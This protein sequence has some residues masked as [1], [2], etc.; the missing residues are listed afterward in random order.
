[1]TSVELFHLTE[2]EAGSV[3]RVELAG[4]EVAIARVGDDIY[5]IGDKCSHADVPLSEG[6]VDV[7]E[8]TIECSAHGALFDLAT[9]EPL[10]L[11]AV[12]PVPVYDVAVVD[13]MVVL[14]MDDD[15]DG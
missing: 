1:M 10:T 15:S 6:W 5:A 12:R 7:E 14:T 13:G 4:R 2:I 9:G 8:C 3:R 11:P